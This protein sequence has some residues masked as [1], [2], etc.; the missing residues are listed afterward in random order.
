MAFTTGAIGA[1]A[2]P[3]PTR[4]AEAVKSLLESHVSVLDDLVSGL[5]QRLG[6]APMAEP[7]ASP[8]TVVPT[9]HLGEL[10]SIAHR[11]DHHIDRLR[12]ISTEV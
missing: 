4:R 11:L 8:A 2:R 5:G 1:S 6:V 9:G 12:H 10:E 7:A 3:E